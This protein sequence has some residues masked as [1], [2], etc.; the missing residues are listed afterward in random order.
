MKYFIFVASLYIFLALNTQNI[1]AQDIHQSSSYI[2]LNSDYYHLID[3]YEIKQK[4]FAKS[5]FT[6][7]KPYSRQAIVAFAD[8]L[9]SRNIS[10]SEADKFNLNYFKNDSWEFAQE[11]SNNSKKVF[12]KK[13]YKNKSDY[14]FVNE[15]E[16]DLHIKPVVYLAGGKDN[17]LDN[18]PFIS[19]R[20]IE[21]RGTVNK[22]VSF[23][24][25]MTDNLI[26]FPKYVEDE[27]DKQKAI[28]REGFWKQKADAAPYDFFTAKGYINFNLT[29]NIH[30][31]IGYDRNFIGNGYRSLILSDY[32]NSYF[33][34]K[35][36]TKVWRLN[37][38]NIFA[39][40]I[41]D[42]NKV[43]NI[44]PKKYFTFHH[45]SINITD[46]FNL[47]LFE[48]ITF[49]RE[50]SLG[51][52]G[53]DT[54]YLNPI[55]FYR[56]I[57]HDLGDPDNAMLG[58]DFKWNLFNKIQLYGQIVLDELIINEFTS[59]D[60]WWGNKQAAQLGLKY[61]DFGGVKN[62]DFQGELNIVR[63]YMYTHSTNPQYSN[64][65]HYNQAL[66][67]PQGA[68]FYE[69]IGVFRYQPTPKLNLTAKIIYTKTGTDGKG[70]NWGKNIFIDYISRQQEYDNKIAQG[71]ATQIMFFSFVTSYQLKHNFFL[72]LK[73]VIRNYKSDN[74]ALSF[75]NS[76][77][78][79]TIRWNIPQ[80]LAEF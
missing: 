38:I 65:Q 58:M 43:N 48:S 73:Q 28:P 51:N 75:N 59:R 57:E 12:L 79:L 16:F 47:G 1:N 45:L 25:F 10:L 40:A 39:Q 6:S 29:K 2:P 52:N 20:G 72:D 49:S 53:F 30:T 62:L 77:S 44:Y 60:G 54:T 4:K 76:Y 17:I 31:Q 15:K 8:S 70:E 19:T 56:S 66:A 37:Y 36:N 74:V 68:N 27:I 3:R 18:Q 34:L 23:Y 35:L 67:H 9:L 13:F 32:A 24:T 46:N 71:V 42:N 69:F 7:V 55:I 41:A 63:P 33:F 50:D 14:Y 21:L 61:I 11:T 64:Y 5:F 26:R 22:R 78:S 80:R